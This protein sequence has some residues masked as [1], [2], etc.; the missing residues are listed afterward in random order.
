M[1][2]KKND[3]STTIITEISQRSRNTIIDL[4]QCTE[5]NEKQFFE[6]NS[7]FLDFRKL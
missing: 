1:D 5:V 6:K 2:K 4:T 3:S 7:Q